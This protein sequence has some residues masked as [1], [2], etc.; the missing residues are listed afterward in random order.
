MSDLTL[1][2][3]SLQSSTIILLLHSL[4][5]RLIN[6]KRL[7]HA[8]LDWNEERYLEAIIRYLKF[9]EIGQHSILIQSQIVAK[10]V[11]FHNL[12]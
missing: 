11:L 6:N 4:S 5:N 3:M 1:R 10:N 9:L 2:I 8:T 12:V 7:I